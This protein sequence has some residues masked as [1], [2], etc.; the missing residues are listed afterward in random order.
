MN[1]F[2]IAQSVAVVALCCPLTAAPTPA[3]AIP[4]KSLHLTGT[5]NMPFCEVEVATGMP[6]DIRVQFN[7]TTGASNCPPARFDKI[8]PEQLAAQLH[9]DRVVLNPRRHWMMDQV[10]ISGLGETRDFDGVR[11]T[12]MGSIAL[13]D[14]LEA[15]GGKPYGAIET[16]RAPSEYVYA[17]GKPV[18]LLA[19]PGGKV[20]Y[21]MQSYT[22][23]ID[24]SLTMAKLSQ[25]GHI[26]K[27]PAGWTFTTKVL[28]RDLVVA[29]PAP[30]F[31]AHTTVDNLLNV[32]A[33]CGFDSAC[34]YIP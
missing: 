8:N 6:P 17:K 14:F 32:Y 30:S 4:G 9:A 22:N 13:K 24:K 19:P 34:N 25:L 15:A 20:V 27:L 16:N 31:T 33:G 23:H 10:S 29:P 2:R 3:Q 21:V 12:W 18:Y 26:L 1:L 7:N 11:A 28:D 5:R